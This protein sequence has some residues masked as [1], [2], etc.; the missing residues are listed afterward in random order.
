MSEN[1]QDFE[2]NFR[3]GWWKDQPDHRDYRFEERV[4]KVVSIPASAD[5]RPL[6]I[7]VLNQGSIG[8]CVAFG[9][10]SCFEA[11]QVLRT[12]SDFIGSRLAEYQW[13]RKEGGYFPGDNGTTI[14]AG[15]K[16]TVDY[17]VAHDT[18]WPYVTSKMDTTIP[19]N[20]VDD[21]KKSH[22]DNYYLV[23]SASG[24]ASTLNNIKTALGV[25]GLPVVFGTPVYS[26]IFNVG[27][28]GMIPLPSGASVGGHCM[29]IVGYSDAKGA[30]LVLNSWGTGWGMSGFGWLPYPYVLQ[31]LVTDCWVIAAESEINPSPATQTTISASKQNPAVGEIIT[32]VATLKSGTTALPSKS[33][34]IYHM[35]NGAR[36][37]DITGIT[38]AA[39]QVT[40][41]QKFDSAGVRTYYAKFAGDTGYATSTSA[42][43]DINVGAA[44]PPAPLTATKLI[45]ETPNITPIVNTNVTFTATLTTT[46][47]PVANKLVRITHTISPSGV[48][49]TDYEGLTD[50]SGK[51]GVTTSFGS[52][53]VRAYKATSAADTVYAESTSAVLNVDVKAVPPTPSPFASGPSVCSQSPTS[54]DLF[55]QGQDKALWWRH[56]DGTTW[57][58]WKSLGGVLTSDPAAMSEG[59]GK[60]T[61]FVRGTDNALWKISTTDG[62]ATWSAWSKEP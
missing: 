15:V 25:T 28:D 3:P 59:L 19:Q 60:M 20:V 12:G 7:R 58:V 48:V 4:M 57:S 32:L 39:G 11:L 43:L 54:M 51:V 22:T 53:G 23:D 52:V 26:S 2:K 18:L 8:S 56:W 5:L 10:L 55:V 46:S 13:G 24:Y 36:Y 41:T 44:P 49:Y 16:A 40:I 1:S 38:N 47:G 35:F 61:V 31:G 27:S 45:L 29:L 62:G 42:S 9:T 50:A 37:D 30:L 34:L 33:V 17:G 14:R 6:I 21:A